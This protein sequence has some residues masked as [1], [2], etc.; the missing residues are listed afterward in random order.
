MK[1]LLSNDKIINLNIDDSSIADVYQKIYKNLSHVP[2]PFRPWDNPYYLEN[3]SYEIL[4]DYLCQYGKNLSV[5]VD[6][7]L[8][9]QQNQEY[10][11][12]IHKIYEQK[13]DG[14]PNWLD[15]HEHI[16]LCEFY[17][18]KKSK[19]LQLDY[20]EKAG[21]LEKK[22]D[23]NWMSTAT[24]KIKKGDIYVYWAELGKNPYHYWEN[25]EP[26][27]LT[28]LCELAKPWLKLRPKLLIALE[29]CDTI[30]GKNVDEFNSWWEKYRKIWCHHWGIDS[31]TIEDMFAVVVF[32]KV[33]DVDLLIE[34]LKD[35]ALPTRVLL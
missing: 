25:N 28:R 14:T 22:F 1:L 18:Q 5:D 26:T 17:F 11:N 24:T 31:W 21:L 8:C 20:R 10:F 27:D 29:D 16:H 3:I 19:P 7:E 15:F 2:V 23:M 32:G 34:Y 9:L 33:P 13:Y 30:V 6:K 12:S 35:N 4:V